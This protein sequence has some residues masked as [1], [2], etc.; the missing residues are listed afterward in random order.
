M[1]RALVLVFRGPQRRSVLRHHWPVVEPITTQARRL[2]VWALVAC[3]ITGLV[4][5]APWFWWLTAIAF[6]LAVVLATLK[7]DDLIHIER[8]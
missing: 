1:A 5:N 3:P 8:K 6:W 7:L 2:A 4:L